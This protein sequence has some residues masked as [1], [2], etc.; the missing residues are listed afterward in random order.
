MKMKFCRVLLSVLVL[1]C[2]QNM[3]F[4]QLRKVV[5]AETVLNVY[6]VEPL[7]KVNVEGDDYYIF[8]LKSSEKYHDPIGLWLGTYEEMISNLK[9]FAVALGEGKKG[10]IFEYYSHGIN[11]RIAFHRMLGERCLKVYEEYGSVYGYLNRWKIDVILKH[12]GENN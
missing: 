2:F 4:A 7:K 10:E 6:M 1:A 11:Y 9:D 8:Y 12:F 3:G 5:T